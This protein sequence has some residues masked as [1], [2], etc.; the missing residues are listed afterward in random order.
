MKYLTKICGAVCL[1]FY[2]LFLYQVW[3]LCQYGGIR[4]HMPLLAFG[5]IGF[6]ASLITGLVLKRQKHEEVLG[7]GLA[8]L[9]FRMEI[10]IGLLGTVFFG[11]CVVYAALPYNG[12]LSWKLDSLMKEKKVELAHDNFFRDGA[13]GFLTD[14]DKAFGLPE[15]LYVV[16]RFR[17]TFDG[18]GEIQAIE[19]FLH[20]KDEKGE[21]RT[22]LVD[23]DRARGRKM[24]V[25]LDGNA[26]GYDGAK[27]LEP[28]LRILEKADCSQQV[29]EWSKDLGAG[30][31]EIL[32][33]G[34]RSFGSQEGLKLLPGDVD[35][36]G[37]DNGVPDLG[38]LS[39][40]WEVTGFEVSL[41]I[42][43][44]EGVTP[45][46]YIMEPEYVS[47]D[48]LSQERVEEQVGEA[49]ETKGWTVD[50]SDGTMY[51]FLDGNIGWRLAVIDAA[52]GSRF[53]GM[54]KTADGGDTW[55]EI[56]ADPFL[57]DIGVTEGLLF[58]DESFGI[59]GLTGASQSDSSLFLTRDGGRSFTR[60]SLPM[61]TVTQL[62]P[63]AKECGFTVEDYDYI[64]MPKKE[65][66]TLTVMVST[67]AIDTEGILFLSEDNGESWAY[68]GVL[69]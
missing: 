42:P 26:A 63:L 23:Y 69:P 54:E 10:L 37:E 3:H 21:E 53:Y 68:T 40:G 47:L 52:A 43:S 24:T 2:L 27:H 15:E 49:V 16:N 50:Q 18:T 20:G 51:F 28:M 48:V 35:G 33:Y 8:N 22:Y 41:H 58:F 7:Q 66:D 60:L 44:A 62:P 6:L 5:A 59:A 65:E 61:D 45:V 34:K 30:I 55:D 9:F 38:Q 56:N 19:T 31:Y 17:M 13:D 29:Q 11:V 39:T 1:F 46:R 57:G 14:L 64:H 12:A 32:Y 36:D 67:E 25:W 4:R